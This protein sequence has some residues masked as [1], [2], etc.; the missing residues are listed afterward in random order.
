[1]AG[2]QYAFRSNFFLLTSVLHL[3]KSKGV[4]SLRFD[5]FSSFAIEIDADSVDIGRAAFFSEA[6]VDR[7]NIYLPCN[8]DVNV[9]VHL[10]SWLWR[11][12][13]GG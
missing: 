5:R 2:N 7:L 10:L 9:F 1:M 12:A 8:Y 4:L 11:R 3:L 6:R 13:L